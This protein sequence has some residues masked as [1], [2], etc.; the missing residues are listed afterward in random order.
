ME[1]ATVRHDSGAVRP[2]RGADI[3]AKAPAAATRRQ[4]GAACLGRHS[5]RRRR[6]PL[7]KGIRRG[8]ELY[9]SKIQKVGNL[10][11]IEVIY[12]IQ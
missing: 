10:L 12:M 5:S 2:A 4:L 11:C 3:P 6:R 8:L 9:T 7:L 1:K